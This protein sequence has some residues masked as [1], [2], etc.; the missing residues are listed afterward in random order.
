MCLLNSVSKDVF[1]LQFNQRSLVR[2]IIRLETMVLGLKSS[3]L[4]IKGLRGGLFRYVS[5]YLK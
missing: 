5:E 4:K 3:K 1:R 2:V